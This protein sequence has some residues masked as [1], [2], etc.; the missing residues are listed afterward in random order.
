LAILQ[1]IASNQKIDL[2]VMVKLLMT[3]ASNVANKVTL[4]KI[5]LMKTLD[6]KE[7]VAVDLKEV[8]A[9]DAIASTKVAE[10]A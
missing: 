8:F 5:A 6:L 9:A 1:E 4:R 3:T 10:T 7:E 2:R